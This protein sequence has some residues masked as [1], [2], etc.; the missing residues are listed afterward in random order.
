MKNE[1]LTRQ[2][3]YGVQKLN[4]TMDRNPTSLNAMVLRI[5]IY[6]MSNILLSLLEGDAYDKDIIRFNKECEYAKENN[7]YSY[8]K[9][10]D[11]GWIESNLVLTT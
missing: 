7:I 2:L 9:E 11:M 1:K 4:A 6:C 8:W 3:I 5:Q 10:F